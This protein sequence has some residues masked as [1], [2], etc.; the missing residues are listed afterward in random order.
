MNIGEN[1]FSYW[2]RKN[3]KDAHSGLITQDFDFF[4]INTKDKYFLI[5]EE[6]NSEKA[7]IGSAQKVIFKMLNDMFYGNNNMEYKF[8][9][10]IT[11]YVLNK[12]LSPRSVI[13]M[14]SNKIKTYDPKEFELESYVLDRLWDCKEVSHYRGTAEERSFYRG[15]N[16]REIFR[17]VKLPEYILCDKVDWIFLNYC[18]GYFILVEEENKTKKTGERKEKFISIIDSIFSGNVRNSFNPKSQVE[19]K[20]LGYYKI[21]FSGNSP[22][23]SEEIY[24]NDNKIEKEELIN[25]LNLETDKIKHYKKTW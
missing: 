6:K 18:T 20:Y 12:N 10:V 16:I 1:S 14:I 13:E 21:K 11:L 7:R 2:M 8:R 22:Y 23:D 15:S 3:L 25:L 5:I 17:N 9:G 24:L 19:Y 4:I